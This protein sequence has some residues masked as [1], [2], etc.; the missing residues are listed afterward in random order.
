MHEL[1]HHCGL[2]AT[3]TPD[4]AYWD[5]DAPGLS[6]PTFAD[7]HLNTPTGITASG[8]AAEDALMMPVVGA[9]PWLSAV[10]VASTAYS[11]NLCIP[12]VTECEGGKA[13]VRPSDDMPYKCGTGVGSPTATT[14]SGLEIALFAS[15]GILVFGSFIVGL[16]LCA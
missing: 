4:L 3:G 10:S 16:Q 2:C 1:G 7:Y 14:I 9:R 13:C 5:V 8:F 6:A 12:G 15:T 11:F